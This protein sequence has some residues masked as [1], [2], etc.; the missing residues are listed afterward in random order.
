MSRTSHEARRDP[1]FLV[2][3]KAATQDELYEVL[4]RVAE[5]QIDDQRFAS[6]LQAWRKLG[7]D[8]VAEL[9]ARDFE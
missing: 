1:A 3:L 5:G 4:G 2:D 9:A 7:N 6:A 8:V